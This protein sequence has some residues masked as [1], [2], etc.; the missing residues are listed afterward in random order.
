MKKIILFVLTFALALCTFSACGAPDEDTVNIYLPD[1]APALALVS[2]FDRTEIAGQ[3]VKFTIVPSDYISSA[4]TNGEADLA[5]VPTN[6]AAN[7]Y[8]KN[9]GYK[10]VSANTHGNLYVV[11]K[12]DLNSFADLKGKRVG[13]IGQGQVPDLVFRSL[14]V[15]EGIEYET[16]DTPIDGKVAISYVAAAANLF[17]S[18]NAD[19]I[20]FGVF[21]EPAVATALSKVEGTKIAMDL[22]QQW[23]GGY[24]QAGLV[25]KNEI[26]DA[27]IKGLFDA[28]R[29]DPDFAENDPTQALELIKACMRESTQTV[30][31]KLDADIVARCNIKLVPAEECKDKVI[32]FLSALGELAPNAIGGKVPDDNFFR[33]VK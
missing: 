13:V 11:G 9:M 27:F 14:L 2:I 12:S 23:G 1:G 22:Q 17:P 15:R 30:I 16:S 5:I 4:V 31:A 18:L 25:A 33:I 32:E 7:L 28:L 29:E 26:D 19:K 21:A 3:K 24:P 6:L 8:N 20:E 10:F